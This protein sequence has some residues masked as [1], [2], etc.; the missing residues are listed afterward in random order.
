VNGDIIGLMPKERILVQFEKDDLAR[1]R[2]LARENKVSVAELIRRGVRLY[3]ERSRSITE[4]TQGHPQSGPK[5]NL[6]E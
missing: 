6:T 1:L 2:E 3:S 4:R 5:P